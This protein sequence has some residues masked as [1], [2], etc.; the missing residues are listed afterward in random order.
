VFGSRRYET[1]DDSKNNLILALLT[2][3]GRHNHLAIHLDPAGVLLV[4]D[5]R[6]VLGLH[7]PKLGLI[8]DLRRVPPRLGRVGSRARSGP[9]QRPEGSSQ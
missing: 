9:R 7:I 1:T 5:R 8:W 6:D 2:M 4:G 3:G